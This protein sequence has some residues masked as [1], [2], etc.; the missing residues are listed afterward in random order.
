MPSPH[1]QRGRYRSRHRAFSLLELMIAVVVVA[2]LAAVLTAGMAKAREL[3]T[4]TKCAGQLR[5]LSTGLS[6]FINDRGYYPGVRVTTR[7]TTWHHALEPY[8]TGG[9]IP[10]TSAPASY[11]ARCPGNAQ[12]SAGPLGYSYNQYFGNIPPNASDATDDSPFNPYW[13]IRPAQVQEPGKKIVIGDGRD[14]GVESAFSRNSLR[15]S[16]NPKDALHPRRHLGGG[17][18]LFADGHVERLTPQE[19]TQLFL[20][21]PSALKPF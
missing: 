6:N 11:W 20:A 10:A 5:A 4:G 7:P 13:Q 9:P 8:M 2:I 16:A 3:A 15:N 17:N 1:L 14:D 18:F 12:T 21:T 19:L